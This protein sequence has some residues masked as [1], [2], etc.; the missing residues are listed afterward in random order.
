MG[1]EWEEITVATAD[2]RLIS[3]AIIMCGHER[4]VSWCCGWLLLSSTY[5]MWDCPE[6]PKIWLM[7]LTNVIKMEK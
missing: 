6:T 7:R 2:A 5:S 4:M 1:E 3:D